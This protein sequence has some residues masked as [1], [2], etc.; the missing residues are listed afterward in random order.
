VCTKFHL[1]QTFHSYD[2]LLTFHF[3]F[4]LELFHCIFS[5]VATKLNSAYNMMNV[6]RESGRQL[7]RFRTIS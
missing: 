4:Y 5:R 6:V 7:F 1:D 3:S 2:V